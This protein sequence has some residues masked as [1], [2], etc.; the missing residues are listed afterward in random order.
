MLELF[1]VFLGGSIGATLRYL[2]SCAALGLGSSYHGTFIINII[3]C[4]FLGFVTYIALKKENIINSNLK[5]F[6]TTG[7][8][9]GFTTFSTFSYE[10]FTLIKSGNIQISIIYML[11]SLFVGLFSIAFGMYCAKYTLY[12]NAKLEYMKNSALA[13]ET[14]LESEI[15]E[16]EEE[17]VEM[18]NEYV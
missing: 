8:A 13:T 12:L 16:A 4:L 14:I 2:L 7:I 11:T 1:L 17:L 18:D 5:L 9:G 6:L 3:G 15:D 10:S